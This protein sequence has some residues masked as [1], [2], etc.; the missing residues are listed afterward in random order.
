MIVCPDVGGAVQPR[1]VP[2]HP[3]R[4]IR[5]MTD[6]TVLFEAEP[7]RRGSWC[8]RTRTIRV[9]PR[10]L[11]VERREV[12][13]HERQHALRG[14]EACQPP[15]EELSVRKAVARELIDL[16][17]LG[18]A[19]LWSDDL[20]EVAD[21]LWVTPELLQLRVRWLHPAEQG[22]LR[23]RLAVKEVSA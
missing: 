18:R 9:N 17:D 20:H 16:R 19:L 4:A 5:A 22:Y 11:Q 21:E 12:V 15:A 14:H 13:T 23:R 8:H 7:G 3:W 6:V 10:L 2:F 1:R